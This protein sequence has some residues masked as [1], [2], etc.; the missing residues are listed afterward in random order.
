MGDGDSVPR[1]TETA[2]MRHAGD[3]GDYASH[4]IVVLAAAS[5]DCGVNGL[6]EELVHAGPR[7]SDGP[8]LLKTSKHESHEKE[9]DSV[10]TVVCIMLDTP[11]KASFFAAVG[12]SGMGAGVIDTFLFI[13]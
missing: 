6:A 12:L 7:N 3:D 11:Y 2:E 9:K 10:W 4:T 1:E 5:S 13:R 8:E